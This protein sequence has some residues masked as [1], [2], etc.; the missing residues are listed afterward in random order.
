[1]KDHSVNEELPELVVK[2]LTSK[3]YF[4]AKGSG[5]VAVDLLMKL[6]AASRTPAK[7]GCSKEHVHGRSNCGV[8]T[9]QLKVQCFRQ[10]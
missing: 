1:M 2:G 7:D 8:G 5:K 10:A 3:E 6:P 9:E 4:S